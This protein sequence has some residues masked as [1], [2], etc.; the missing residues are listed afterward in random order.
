M[1][2]AEK[3]SEAEV[4]AQLR[5]CDGSHVAQLV[6]GKSEQDRLSMLSI[7]KQDVQAPAARGESQKC[8]VDVLVGPGYSQT[9]GRWTA[10]VNIIGTKPGDFTG[11]TGKSLYSDQFDPVSLKH[12][13]GTKTPLD[14]VELDIAKVRAVTA[15]LKDKG[16]TDSFSAA[17]KGM[18]FEEATRFS[19]AVV[20]Q[21]SLKNDG[22]PVTGVK[23]TI[24]HLVGKQSPLQNGITREV[25]GRIIGNPKLLVQETVDAD[26]QLVVD[27][28]PD[29]R[30]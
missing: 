16:S 22:D 6:D 25:P 14:R 27:T 23:L 5:Q 13:D 3:F 26:G 8:A 12:S 11:L 28:Y 29:L 15:D 10:N 2:P 7:L 19:Y 9:F 20:D 21:Q 4:A 17:V 18:N 24:Q 30:K 1:A